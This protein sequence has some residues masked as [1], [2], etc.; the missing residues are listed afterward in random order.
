MYVQTN[1]CLCKEAEYI[2]RAQQKT[3]QKIVA[4]SV[5]Q[6]NQK[7]LNEKNCFA[8]SSSNQMDWDKA[9]FNSGY[10]LNND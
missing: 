6:K 5:Q 10:A 2:M 1:L 4:L 9:L 8:W 3:Y 7:N